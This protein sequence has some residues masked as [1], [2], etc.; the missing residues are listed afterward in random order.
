MG[1]EKLQAN[2]DCCLYRAVQVKNKKLPK[3]DVGCQFQSVSL[4]VWFRAREAHLLT[5][6]RHMHPILARQQL[7]YQVFLVEQA[8]Q[9]PFNRAALLNVGVAETK[10]F[11][12]FSCFVFHDVD[13]LPEDDRAVYGCPEGE[14]LHLAV[15]VSRWKYRLVHCCT[16]SL[17]HPNIKTEIT[18]WV[19]NNLQ[20]CL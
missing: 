2:S 19:T 14:A 11:G 10:Q 8:D 9:W 3:T 20:A 5:W 15:A 13:I 4:E 12:N 1:S 16:M 6:L 18:W 7:D 17:C